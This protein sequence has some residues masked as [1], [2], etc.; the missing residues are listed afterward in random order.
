MPITRRDSWFSRKTASGH[1]DGSFHIYQGKDGAIY[2]LLSQL[3]TRLTSKQ[4]DELS[5]DCYDLPDFEHDTYLRAYS[6]NNNSQ[7]CPQKD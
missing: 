7:L 3:S 2:L 4:L 5:I 6:L 1:T